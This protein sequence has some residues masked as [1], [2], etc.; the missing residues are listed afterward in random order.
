M[1]EKEKC[2]IVIASGS[3]CK[4]SVRR[5]GLCA[6]HLRQL[7]EKQSGIRALLKAGQYATAATALIK[8]IEVIYPLC[9]EAEKYL[10]KTIQALSSAKLAYV[11]TAPWSRFPSPPNDRFCVSHFLEDAK[12]CDPGFAPRDFEIMAQVMMAAFDSYLR[13]LEK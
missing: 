3:R 8:F 11:C 9:I 7:R 10:A 12:E 5:K 4:N 1:T 2:R 6:V 13:K